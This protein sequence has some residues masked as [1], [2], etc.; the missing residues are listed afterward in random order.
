MWAE[1]VKDVRKDDNTRACLWEPGLLQLGG[2]GVSCLDFAWRVRQLLFHLS[3]S[4]SF[5]C[6]CLCLLFYLCLE[7]AYLC[8]VS[9]SL[10]FICPSLLS[11]AFGLCLH[12]ALSHSVWT[13]WDQTLPHSI[14]TMFVLLSRASIWLATAQRVSPSTLWLTSC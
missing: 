4:L 10:G 11:T 3:A 8:S 7:C 9:Q 1:G 13:S 6:I 5:N 12:W 2:F 14:W